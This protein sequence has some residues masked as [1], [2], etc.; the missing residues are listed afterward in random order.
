MPEPG[1]LGMNRT[2]LNSPMQKLKISR[3]QVRSRLAGSECDKSPPSVTA[4]TASWDAICDSVFA[5]PAGIGFLPKP[6][7]ETG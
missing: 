7:A 4:V 6:D 1:V 2:A 5:A 3:Q